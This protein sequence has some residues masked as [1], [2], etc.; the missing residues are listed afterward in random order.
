LFRMPDREPLEK[1]LTHDG[2]DGG[3]GADAEGESQDGDGS[4][5]GGFLEKAEGEAGVLKKGFE[6]REG[7][8]VAHGFLGLFEAAEFEE[9]V[10]AGGFGGHTSGE[11]VVNVELKV[12]GQLGV[13]FAVD[14][15]FAEEILDASEE[16]GHRVA[17][18]EKFVAG[19]R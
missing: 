6:E 18:K 5:G 10:A 1:N 8:F 9:G 13:E 14:L 15:G 12:G 19:S 11:V 3:V 4:E 2:K 17:S 7:L 16:G